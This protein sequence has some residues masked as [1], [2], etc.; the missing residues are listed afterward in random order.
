MSSSPIAEPA[1]SDAPK[2]PEIDVDIDAEMTDTKP[3]TA[4]NANGA[5]SS[6]IDPDYPPQQD[7]QPSTSSLHHNRKDAT[8]REFLSKMD[9]YAPVVRLSFRKPLNHCLRARSIPN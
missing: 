3:A 4:P 8:L 5:S 9:D 7:N 6:N 2:D 1:A